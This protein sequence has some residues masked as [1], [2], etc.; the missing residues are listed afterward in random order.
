LFDVANSIRIISATIAPILTKGTQKI[1]KA[2][3]FSDEQLKFENL[4][5][6]SLMENYNLS[7]YEVEPIYNR[8]K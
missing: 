4:D 3:N 1:N 7:N 2:M 8:K 5:N 6:D